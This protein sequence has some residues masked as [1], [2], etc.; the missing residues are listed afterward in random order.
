M[1]APRIGCRGRN[2]ESFVNGT[3]LRFGVFIPPQHPLRE[4]PTLLF[5]RDLAVVS[6]CDR[7][8]FEEAWIGEHHSGGYETIAAPELVIAV[9]AERTKTIRLGTGVRSLPYAHPFMVA[10]TIVQLDHM[11]RGR[12]MFG[13]GPGALPM[14]AIQLGV[15]P[16]RTREMMVEALEVII[17]LLAGETVSA[18]T[19]WFTLRDARL[20][21]EPLTRPRMEIAVTSVRSPAGA[22]LA[23]RFGLG[24]LSLGG[25]SDDA[26]EKYAEHGRICQETAAKHGQTVDP[27]RHRIAVPVHIAETRERA[28]A[29]M[30]FG[31]EKWADYASDVLPFSPLGA[32]SDNRLEF[33]METRR[34]I[35]GTP[36]DAIA[37]IEAIRAGSGG[38]GAFLIMEQNWA[39][40]AAA[41][42]S[43]EMFARYVIPHFRRQFRARQ[44]SYDASKA[45]HASYVVAAR[46]GVA[47]AQERYREQQEAT[48]ARNTG[49]AGKASS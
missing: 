39:D 27:A 15:D 8:G 6:L 34:A 12:V 44:R 13:I 38:M 48:V 10:D 11:T 9:A 21:I 4:N 17:P 25:A 26:L 18:E 2:R 37:A 16:S 42:R 40:W 32:V 14:D 1:S 30:G 29:D 5:E 43:Y 20:Q 47:N 31:F 24:T 7:L 35:I 46:Q 49:T 41:D 45:R 36:D 19:D 33:V 23:G 22:M 3:P 28:I